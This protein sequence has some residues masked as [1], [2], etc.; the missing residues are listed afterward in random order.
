MEILLAFNYSTRPSSPGVSVAL[1]DSSPQHSRSTYYHIQNPRKRYRRYLKANFQGPQGENGCGGDCTKAWDSRNSS[2]DRRMSE[3]RYTHFEENLGQ[4]CLEWRSL[5]YTCYL[6]S[7]ST[8]GE[9]AA[10][11][12]TK[13]ESRQTS[14]PLEDTALSDFSHHSRRL[15]S[16]NLSAIL[17][18]GSVSCRTIPI[19]TKRLRRVHKPWR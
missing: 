6:A 7:L 3:S 15:L 14:R 10:Q 2:H 13:V 1:I 8:L 9:S 19:F 17:K 5:E 4:T 12:L 18:I 16:H 11:K